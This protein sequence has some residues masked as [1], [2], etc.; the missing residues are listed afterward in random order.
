MTTINTQPSDQRDG[1]AGGTVGSSSVDSYPVLVISNI[2]EDVVQVQDAAVAV[3]QPVNLQPV[4]GV[5]TEEK[6]K[7]R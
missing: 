3:L 4:V 1:K 5:L 6:K 2:T 7:K